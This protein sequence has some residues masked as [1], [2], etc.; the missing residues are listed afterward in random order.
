MK[1]FDLHSSVL[2]QYKK[3]LLSF[4][5]IKDKRIKVRVSEAVQNDE[6]VLKPSLLFNPSYEVMG[7]LV[8]LIEKEGWHEDLLKCFREYNL[9]RH[10]AE[11]IQL[12]TNAK[13]FVVTSGTGSGK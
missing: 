5:T 3:Y 9:F 8:D 2:E 12:G 10:Q 6:L 11:A 4:I 1:A 13:D 7:K